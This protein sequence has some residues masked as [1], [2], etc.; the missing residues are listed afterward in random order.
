M[1]AYATKKKRPPRWTAAFLFFLLIFVLA[2][3]GTIDGPSVHF[4]STSGYVTYRA[5]TVMDGDHNAGVG[6]FWVGVLPEDH[7]PVHSSFLLFDFKQNLRRWPN[8]AGDISRSP[9]FRLPL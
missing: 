3:V 6:P 9:P 7:P 4:G 5:P 2:F 8:V 1:L